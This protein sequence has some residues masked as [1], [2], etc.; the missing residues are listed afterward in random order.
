LHLCNYKLLSEKLKNKLWKENAFMKKTKI[1]A[2]RGASA[3]APENTIAAFRKA[4]EMNADGIELDV[5]LSKDNHIVVIHDSKVNRTSNGDGAVAGMTLKELKQ[6]DF[7]GWFSEEYS[8]EKIPTLEEVLDLL[9][10]WNGLLNIEMK[11]M[12]KLN[13]GLEKR[14][15]DMVKSWDIMDKIIISSFNH[16]SLATIKKLEPDIKIGLLYTAGLYEP[17]NYAA[18]LKADA[19][20]PYYLAIMPEIVRD[21]HAH[22]I[23]VNPYTVDEPAHIAY[24]LSSKVDGIITNVPDVA[25]KIR[26]QD[27]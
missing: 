9:K 7:G 22:G 3:Y 18:S 16:Y 15:L 4:L 25:I 5:H 14:L 2:H 21:C 27:I 23:Q 19:I 12:P 10:D 13:E 20:H 1:I 11:V 24:M 8:Q 6:L 17:W 26:D